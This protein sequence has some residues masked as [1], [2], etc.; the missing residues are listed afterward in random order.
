MGGMFSSPKP[1]DPECNEHPNNTDRKR[2][3]RQGTLQTNW[4]GLDSE[5]S[6]KPLVDNVRAETDD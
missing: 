5:T 1:A 3:G 6:E 4:Q 2:R